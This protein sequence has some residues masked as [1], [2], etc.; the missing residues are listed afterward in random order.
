M[1]EINVRRWNGT[2]VTSLDPVDCV[3]G[4]FRVLDNFVYDAQGFPTVRGGRR[5]WNATQVTESGAPVTFY[6][7]YS[8]RK[9]WISERTRN[10]VFAYAGT[11]ILKSEHDGQWDVLWTGLETGLRATWATL[12]GWLFFAS[13]SESQRKILY[14]PDGSDTLRTLHEGPD[15]HIVTAHAG[16]LFAVD[17]NEASTLKYSALYDPLK[18]DAAS[19]GGEIPILP[20]DGNQISALVPG[21]A[22]DLIV[23]KT[24][25][26]GG[27]T[28]R[29]QGFTPSQ[30]TVPVPLS[31]TLGAMNA[32]G[33]SMIGDKDIFFTSPRGIHSLSRVFEYGDLES[34]FLDYEI[35]DIWRTLSAQAKAIAVAVDDYTTDNWYLFYDSNADG[36]NDR[37]LVFNYRHLGPQRA[38]GQSYPKTSRLLYGARAATVITDPKSGEIRLMTG[39]SDGYAYTENHPAA[40]DSGTDYAWEATLQSVDAGDAFAMKAWGPL[41]LVHDNWGDA[42]MTVTWYGDNRPPSDQT[43]SLNT[44]DVPTPYSGTAQ[45]GEFRGVPQLKARNIVLL[46]EGGVVLN[47][48]FTGTRGRTTLRSFGLQFEPLRRDVASDLWFRSKYTQDWANVG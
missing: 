4:D 27:S 17:Q 18:W 34:A 1:P 29:L 37:A 21:F 38:N 11:K 25:P 40:N 5:R 2:L 46:R 48:G 42:D 35:S 12:R 39:G 20:G 43:I 15:A 6:S 10:W 14:W 30:F 31:T 7:L 41:W 28:Y 13:S 36:V 3:P 32:T 23:F 45:L 47:L 8:F 16:R 19:G 22:G 24:G 26:G 9:G 44:A 33:W